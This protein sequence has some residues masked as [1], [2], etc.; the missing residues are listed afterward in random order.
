MNNRHSLPLLGMAA[1]ACVALV[2]CTTS[3]SY[4]NSGYRSPTYGSSTAACYD[5]GTVTHIQAVG[6][7][8]TRSGATGAVIGGL[9]GAAAGREIAEDESTG[10]RNTATVAGAA[11][12]ALAGSAIQ[13][14][15][16]D[17]AGYNVTVRMDD[18]RLVTVS[19]SDLGGIREGSYV[20]VANGRA[21]VR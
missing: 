8:G 4:G 10:R 17:N 6:T 12:G 7:T 16:N 9:V 2:G 18:G 19:Q 3:P 1:A 5:C 20:R 11:A 21:W 15:M 13:R 14:N